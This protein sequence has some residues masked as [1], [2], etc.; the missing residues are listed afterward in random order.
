M[1]PSLEE[2]F[3]SQFSSDKPL[4]NGLTLKAA[5]FDYEPGRTHVEDHQDYQHKDLLP[6]FPDIHWNPLT[7]V[8]Y[9][10]KGLLGDPKFR[11]LLEAAT[12]V[13][14]FTPKIGTEISGIRLANLSDAQKNDLARLIAHRGVVFF[15]G[16]HDF[17]INAQREL[18]KYF[19]KLHKA[20]RFS[21]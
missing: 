10:D 5:T 8:P 9:D 3:F 12:D 21:E 16:Q 15:R 18:G 1:A 7:K 20:G 13:F 17:D 2:P 6:Y 11:N 19:G 4:K 14:D